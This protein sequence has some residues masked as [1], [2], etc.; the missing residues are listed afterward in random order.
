MHF[1][2]RTLCF[3]GATE[4][5]RML[6][7]ISLVGTHRKYFLKTIVLNRASCRVGQIRYLPKPLDEGE[8]GVLAE[9]FR[10]ILLKLDG[11]VVSHRL[12]KPGTVYAHPWRYLHASMT[13]APSTRAR[14]AAFLF[15][16]SELTFECQLRAAEF[17]STAASTWVESTALGGWAPL[18]AQSPHPNKRILPIQSVITG[19]S[20]INVFVEFQ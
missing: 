7:W 9:G 11:S 20:H 6:R 19:T 15:Q 3:R 8:L 5:W 14:C 12:N 18:D 17:D 16:F 2:R 13:P 4:I 10:D 1:Q